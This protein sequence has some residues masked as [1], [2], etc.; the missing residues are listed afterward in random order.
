MRMR[1]GAR[2]CDSSRRKLK[3]GL[4][5]QEAFTD[6][7]RRRNVQKK[8]DASYYDKRWYLEEHRGKMYT[9]LRE[10]GLYL[11]YARLHYETVDVTV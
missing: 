11:E 5:L 7:K 10:G 2:L 1:T 8:Q 9:G 3:F 6:L 4:L